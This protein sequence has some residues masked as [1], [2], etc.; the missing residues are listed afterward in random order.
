MSIFIAMLGFTDEQMLSAAKLGVLL[1]SFVAAV[2]GLAWGL[3]Y[4]RGRQRSHILS[5]S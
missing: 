2:A 1:G 4:V 5:A 3:F